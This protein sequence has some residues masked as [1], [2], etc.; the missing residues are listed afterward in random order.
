[1]KTKTGITDWASEQVTW[2]Y[3]VNGSATNLTNDYSIAYLQ[4]MNS[5]GSGASVNWTDNVSAEILMAD[6]GLPLG[7]E[8]KI[9][10]NLSGLD[11]TATYTLYAMDE[12]SSAKMLMSYTK[13]TMAAGV[14]DLTISVP[15][16]NNLML[17]PTDLSLVRV[18]WS[19][20]DTIEYHPTELKLFQYKMNEM[21]L[22]QEAAGDATDGIFAGYKDFYMLDVIH[23]EQIRITLSANA[24]GYSI[25]LRNEVSA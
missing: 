3:V 11:A 19:N 8:K 7:T 2:D 13:T 5:V 20:G 10:L 22:V 9:L 23:A 17:S 1:M 16:T 14:T 15:N 4:E 21:V 18:K 25:Y 6:G 24:S 12:P